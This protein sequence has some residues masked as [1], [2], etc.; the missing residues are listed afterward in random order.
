MKAT[1]PDFSESSTLEASSHSSFLPPKEETAAF[2]ETGKLCT[3]RPW[4]CTN[5]GH[6]HVAVG[7][8]TVVPLGHSAALLGRDFMQ[9]FL[10]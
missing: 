1:L 3:S 9:L 8:G 4:C 7:D 10:Y 6:P 5:Q 2:P